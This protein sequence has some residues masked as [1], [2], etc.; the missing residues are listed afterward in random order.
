MEKRDWY[1]KEK[2]ALIAREKLPA[3]GRWKSLS[4]KVMWL[5]A[6]GR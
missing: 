6:T 4:T 3:W 5:C 2:G 1:G